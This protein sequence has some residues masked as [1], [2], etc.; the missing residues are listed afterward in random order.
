ML[1][2]VSSTLSSFI[3]DHLWERV[4][5]AEAPHAWYAFYFNGRLHDWGA[6]LLPC[7]TCIHSS[8]GSP[9][10]SL[11]GAAGPPAASWSQLFAGS[12]LD[13]REQT[14]PLKKEDHEKRKII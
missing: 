6:G 4:Q 12:G 11:L 2:S 9:S 8:P 1:A 5:A 3:H 13:G 14:A 7:S 10:P